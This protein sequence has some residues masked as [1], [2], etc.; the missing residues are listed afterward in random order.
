MA[1]IQD[2]VNNRHKYKE[3]L[4][5]QRTEGAWSREDEQCLIDTILRNEPMPLF[6]FNLKT[7][8]GV[9]YVVDVQQRLGA[10]A[11]FY[12]NKF[13]LN[14]KFSGEDNHGKNFNGNNPI[15]DQQRENFLGYHLNFKI[16]EDY[17]DEKIRTIFSRLQRGKPLTLDEHL[18]AMPGTVV[19]SMR[20]IAKHPFMADSIGISKERYGNFPDAARILFYET[21]GARDSGTPA[22][23][24]FFAVYTMVS[25]LDKRYGLYGKEQL[26]SDFLQTFHGNVYMEDMRM[27]NHNYQRFYDNVRGGWSERIISFR[28]DTLIQEFIKKHQIQELDLR[29][30]INEQK[31]IEVFT[32]AGRKCEDC[33]KDF[34]DHSEPEYHHVKLYASGGVSDTENIKALCNTCHTR[35]RGKEEMA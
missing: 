28:R 9:Y 22:L 21:L 10:I 34:K 8:E 12:D 30:Q 26:I 5:Y 3:D 17:D 18:N 16:M 1:T 33:G 14:S 2:Y 19:I 15:S 20:E 31:K 23:T 4:D 27:S 29:R 32:K 13:S 6:F 7:K 25:E 24:R 11:R 35:Y